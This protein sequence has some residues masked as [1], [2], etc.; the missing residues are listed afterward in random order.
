MEWIVQI[1]THTPWW[2]YALFVFLVS[3]GLRALK[4]AD[5]APATLALIPLV[6]IVW[7]LFD[8]NRLY[9]IGAAT[10]APWIVA[11]AVG[12]AVG[13][14]ILRGAP[15][16][17]DRARGMIHRPA[18]YTVLPLILLAFAIKYTFGVMDATSPGL[19]QAPFY[20]LADLACS[21]FFAG[22]FAGKFA[23]YMK[24]YFAAPAPD[25]IAS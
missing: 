19:L 2:V 5:V 1:L 12:G 13:I 3:R 23:I 6:F 22:V 25:A 15:L 24:A 7:G 10:L 17:A 11:L 14:A 21:G 18:D 20:R 8:L 4:P 9:G 16:T